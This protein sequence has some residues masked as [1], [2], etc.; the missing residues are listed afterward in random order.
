[1][2]PVEEKKLAKILQNCLDMVI[3]EGEGIDAALF[4]FPNYAESIRPELEV[5]LW[6][7]DQKQLI[8]PRRGFVQS[9]REVWEIS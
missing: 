3:E 8:E 9:S 7:F 6:L 1:M 5:A 2:N 4:H